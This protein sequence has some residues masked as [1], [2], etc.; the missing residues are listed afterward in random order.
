MEFDV[1]LTEK[2]LNDIFIQRAYKGSNGKM[3]IL[4]GLI[5]IVL[6]ILLR[7][8]GQDLSY[9]LI[10]IILG[11]I[12]PMSLPFRI[13][14]QARSIGKQNLADHYLLN[15]N[16]V[17]YVHGGNH[18]QIP[19]DKIFQVIEYQSGLVLNLGSNQLTVIPRDGNDGCYEAIRA[20]FSRYKE[21]L[22]K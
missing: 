9:T 21:I 6:G 13:R 18:M 15:E 16:G 12:F 20:E 7:T 1:R 17:H 2:G 10:L 5:L 11:I 22:S 3:S 4:S 19:W 8:R 14:R